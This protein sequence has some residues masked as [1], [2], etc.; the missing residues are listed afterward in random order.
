MKSKIKMLLLAVAIN[1]SGVM[2]ANNEPTSKDPKSLTEEIQSL[3]MNPNFI[4]ETDE[5]ARV[6]LIFNRNSEIVV[7]SVDS[8]NDDVEYYIKNRLNYKKLE[9]GIDKIN[10]TYVVPVKIEKK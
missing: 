8:E 6:T 7:M 3:L 5:F 9:I 2:T 4:L 1:F 10:K